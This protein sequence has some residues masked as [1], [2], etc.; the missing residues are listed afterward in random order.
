MIGEEVLKKT[1]FSPKTR[2]RMEFG[3]SSAIRQ[4]HDAEG[5]GD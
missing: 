2:S 4:D 1:W 5:M 3:L